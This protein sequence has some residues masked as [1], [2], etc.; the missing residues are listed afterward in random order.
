MKALNLSMCANGSKKNKKL[1]TRTA[2]DPPLGSVEIRKIAQ[3]WNGYNFFITSWGKDQDGI[4]IPGLVSHLAGWN[5]TW[6]FGH[7]IE[8]WKFHG[9]QT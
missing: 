5:F 3:F 7:P 6:K 4:F 8:K 9:I 2:W 1:V